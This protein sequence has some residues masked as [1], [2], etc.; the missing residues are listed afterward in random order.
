MGDWKFLE[1]VLQES[2]RIEPPHAVPRHSRLEM[3]C[4]TH[5]DQELKALSLKYGFAFFIDRSDG[6]AFLD[7]P[8]KSI[9]PS[10]RL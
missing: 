2:G 9:R 4:E 3:E 7:T 5:S 8:E 10:K 6:S 1:R